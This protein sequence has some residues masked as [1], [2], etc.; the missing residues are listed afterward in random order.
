MERDSTRTAGCFGWLARG[1]TGRWGC[2][3]VLVFAASAKS[4]ELAVDPS[5]GVLHG[6]RGL[7]VALIQAEY[8]L[9]TWLLSG[10]WAIYCRRVAIIV[11][12]TFA[13][14]ALY[15]GLTS[16]ASCG[17]FGL[18]HVSPWVTATLDVA[19]VF[20]LY[21]W[22][23]DSN[24]QLVDST[25]VPDKLI[26]LTLCVASLVTPIVSLVSRDRLCAIADSPGVFV[27]RE[28]VLLDPEKWISA[29]LPVADE[30]DIGE[31]LTTGAWV[32]LLY[33]HDCPRCEAA[34]PHYT[35]RAAQL[36]PSSG[37]HGIALI[38]IPPC[39][40][41]EPHRSHRYQY[42]RLNSRRKW[43]VKTPVELV[44][45]AGQVIGVRTGEDV[46]DGLEDRLIGYSGLGK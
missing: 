16:A 14:V 12:G 5:L 46:I 7:E 33:H 22:R 6:S 29:R 34:I 27:A 10:Y 36:A 21:Q 42:G 18:I 9:A 11:F 43:L 31:R 20:L 23:P 28:Q 37:A 35:N 40:S 24:R 38:E 13:G 45:V 15:N 4:Y 17:C 44:V 30:I 3:A 2:G 26:L 39:D 19:A 32:I 25:D 41:S 8:L 1:T